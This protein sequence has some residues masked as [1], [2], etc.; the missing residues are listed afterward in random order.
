MSKMSK[1]FVSCVLAVAMM[2]SLAPSTAFATDGSTES[3]ST[4]TENSEQNTTGKVITVDSAQSLQDK[5]NDAADGTVTTIELTDN[6]DGGTLT[7]SNTVLTVATIPAGKNIVL[8]LAG[9]TISANL[10]TNGSTY[11]KAH[12]ILNNGTLTIK[13]SSADHTGAIENTNEKS[14]ACTRTIKNAGTGILTINGGTIS[15]TVALL[16]L[17]QCTIDGENVV[18]KSEA[19]FGPGGWDNSSAAIENRDDTAGSGI[20][21]I[22]N[23]TVSSTSRAA[24]FCDG[25]GSCTITGGTF[26]GNADYGDINGSTADRIVTVSGGLW[27]NDPSNFLDR[28][29]YVADEKEN[30][31]FKVIGTTP[32]EKTVYSEAE[33]QD[34][35]EQATKTNP[36]N[37]LINGNI[38][39]SK[40]EE[41]L[42]NSS[43]TI[44]HNASLTIANDTVLTQSGTITNNGTLTVNGFLTNPLNISNNGTI[45]GLDIN[46]TDYVISDAM[47]LQWLT[48]LVEYGH[49]KHVT[50][51]NDVTLPEGVE[52][53]MI[54]SGNNEFYGESANNPVTFNGNNHTISNLVI[55]NNSSNTGLFTRLKYAEIKNLTVNADIQTQT[56]YTG[57]IT[58]YAV[59]GVRFQNI[60]VE[61]KVTVTGG[62]YGCAGIAAAVGSD[63]N[64]ENNPVEFINCHNEASIGGTSGY[65]IGS[66]FGTASKS[67]DSV[68]VYNCSN[69]ST[70][71]AAGSVG[72]VF[73][74][75]YLNAASTLEIIGFTNEGTVNGEA[76][77]ISSAI[78]DK[79]TYKTEYAD[80]TQYKA[81]KQDDEWKAVAANTATADVSGVPYTSFVDAVNAAT[82]GDIINITGTM[83]INSKVE[84]KKDITVT[85]FSNLQVGE[86]GSL[87]IEAGTYDSDPT[88][89]L[90]EGLKAKKIGNTYKVIDADI[91]TITFDANGGSCDTATADT[92]GDGVLTTLPTATQNGYTFDGWFT[93]KDGGNK[94]TTETFFKEDTTLYA[95]WTKNSSGGG[96]VTPT[97]DPEEPSD[98]EETVTNPDGSTTT[99]ITKEDGSSSTT[100]VGTDGKV[101]SDVTVSEEAVSNADGAAVALPIPEVPVTTDKDAAPTVTVNL[102]SKDATK[103]EVPVKDVTPGTVAVLVDADGNET[104]IKDTVQSENGIIVEI[105]DGTTIKVVDN[106]KSFDDVA[107]NYWGADAIDFATSRELFAGT[108]ENTFSPEGDM[109]RAMIWSVLARYEGA[110][111]SGA[112][113]DEWY[114]GPQKWA[115][116]NGISDGTYPNA[117]M[118]REQLAAMLYRYVG[119]PAVSGTVGDYSDADS[120]SS[121]ASDA[122]VWAV[123]EGLIAGMD[124][125]T[126]NPQGTAT[127]T[128][129][130][131]IFQRFIENKMA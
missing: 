13:D 1:R 67:N 31:Y 30:G 117:S 78:G 29:A 6:I 14:N 116:E 36:V 109:T 51:A 76:G 128:Q 111:T 41:L 93:A 121:W 39:L 11:A 107:D 103:V 42:S 32:V 97:P 86:G 24:I 61:G 33:L 47:D 79:F 59:E 96:T 5:I 130:A 17:G 73:G 19:T 120:I 12:V 49:V 4:T 81:V 80:A 126:L 65:N 52:F 38:T 90:A 82:A 62:S 57:G 123:Q 91:H 94:V 124:E 69:S 45:T 55:R 87:N 15:G 9:H 2:A 77:S 16:N 75:G 105:T 48:Y 37:I 100:T 18:I 34:A 108:S 72:Y 115:I 74:Y 131:A 85:G 53:Q 58:G 66:I 83:T 119:S 99:T 3:V 71:T 95:H 60:T 112:S 114:A 54:G 50:L 44:N 84:I 113:G 43:I 89:Y 10:N 106:S 46:A 68:Y 25:A 118:T 7:P 125:D 127:R 98:S 28:L 26:S 56:A 21:T 110:D 64:V 22:N 122:M 23:A 104:V 101:E 92:N 88:D 63:S 8:D 35:L 129:V 70:I 40:S 20:L 27:L 102:P